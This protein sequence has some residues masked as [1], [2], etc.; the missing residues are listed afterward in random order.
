M[1]ALYTLCTVHYTV[2]SIQCTLHSVHCTVYS[3]HYTLYSVVI[4]DV[5]AVRTTPAYH[6]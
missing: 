1:Y 4:C 5:L 3:L 6:P 2:Y